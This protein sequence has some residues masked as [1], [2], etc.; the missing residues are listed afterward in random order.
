MYNKPTKIPDF[1]LRKSL[2]I[3]VAQWL[4]IIHRWVQKIGLF[5]GHMCLVGRLNPYELEQSWELTFLIVLILLNT[6]L[7]LKNFLTDVL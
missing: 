4:Q 3:K 6:K 1:F 5:P 2:E 7:A